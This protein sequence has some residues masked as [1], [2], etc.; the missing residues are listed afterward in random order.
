[1][2]IDDHYLHFDGVK[3]DSRMITESFLPPLVFRNPHFQT[4][5]SS[6]KLRLCR[7][8]AVKKAARWVILDA[9]QG[10][11]LA[12][13]LS[14]PSD[15]PIKGIVILL[16]GWEGSAAS[17]YCV[18]TADGLFRSGYSVFRLNL[19][20]HGGSHHLNQG[21]FYASL[22][23]EVHAAVK[24]AAIM[25]GGLPAFIVGFSLGGNFALRI[26]LRIR[27]EPIEN[28]RYIFCV[29]PVLDPE[30]ATA[31]IDSIAYIRRYFIKKWRRSLV[32]KQRFFP[33]IYNFSC[34]FEKS[35]IG[36][37]T[38]AL[39]ERHSHFRSKKAYFRS[40]TL[41]NDALQ[42]LPLPTTLLTAADDP[43]IPVEDFRDL[44]LNNCTELSIQP[45]GGHNGFIEGFS[46]RS[47]Y[48]TLLVKLFDG[49]VG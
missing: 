19:R 26:A 40:Y 1:M 32:R 41:V 38:E 45:Y 8:L 30:K 14:T 15:R 6:S 37:L 2:F 28:L 22:L 29:S 13:V 23:D 17:T 4:V 12:G 21:L 3:R 24:S 47:W 44:S 11:R 43:I 9:G 48:E 20:D 33:R 27:S 42:E 35:S 7:G 31:R 46:L 34:L 16:H 36:D 10:I 49:I 25:E 18:R 5:L 39:L